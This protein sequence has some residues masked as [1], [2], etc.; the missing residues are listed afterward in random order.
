MFLNDC[1]FATNAGIDWFTYL[2]GRG[3]ANQL[4][5]ELAIAATIANSYGVQSLV[6]VNAVLTGRNLTLSY[7]VQTVFS[8][9]SEGNLINTGTYILTEGGDFLGDESGDRL[10]QE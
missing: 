3:N 4:Q 7:N 1:F 9:I 10:V 2:G 6:Q 5:V 8:G